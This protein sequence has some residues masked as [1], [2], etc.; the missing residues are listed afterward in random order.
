MSENDMKLPEGKTCGDC[1]NYEDCKSLFQRPA[2][3]TVRDWSPSYFRQRE[4][5]SSDA[6]E[7]K[8]LAAHPSAHYERVGDF[9]IGV[10]IDQ[11]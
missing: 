7:T 4:T 9:N 8:K 5:L 1:A 6:Q 3:S 11:D 2:E 10:Y